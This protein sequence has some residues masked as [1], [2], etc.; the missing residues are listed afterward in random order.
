MSCSVIAVFLVS[1]AC[2][3]A[4]LVSHSLSFSTVKSVNDSVN[5]AAV[6]I[7]TKNRVEDL[8]K[9]VASA[10]AQTVPPEVV[11]A[12]DGST[13]GTPDI[14]AEEFP[15]VRVCRSVKSVGYIVQRN[16]AAALVK[17]P[18]IFSID[19]DAVFSTPRIIEQTLAEFD[20]SQVGAVAIPFV[21]VNRSPE[22]KQRAPGIDRVFASYSFI[23]T[24]HALRRE[25]F[26]KLGG[27]REILV[28]Q[29]EEGDYSTRMLDAGYIT[30]C[31]LADP[32]HHFESPRRSW[33]RM[34]YYGS[35]N[36][37]LYSWMNVP[38][39]FFPVHLAV[40]SALAFAFSMERGRF[41]V[42]LKGI[43]AGHA[44][45]LSGR[46]GRK[47]VTADAYRMSRELKGRGAVPLDEMVNRFPKLLK[48][49]FEK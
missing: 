7:T 4:S 20:R 23:G 31:G 32:I 30:R 17:A 28:H 18:I 48:P 6:V 12:D 33:A 11:V 25:L 13:D 21:D 49:R 24:A 1:S 40:T 46:S 36:R 9:A 29:G 22:V 26:L 5:S 19:D 34:D 44:L 38:L 27:Y 8:R 15:Q 43:L 42:R 14:I 10:L 3:A 2:L 41:A 45:G 37:I 16:R 47:A 39:P 35:R